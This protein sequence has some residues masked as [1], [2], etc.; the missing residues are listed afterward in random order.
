MS[1]L[2]CLH[3]EV[4]KIELVLNS[5]EAGGHSKCSDTDGIYERHICMIVSK[6]DY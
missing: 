5:M 4:S 6:M 1:V 2:L 3:K